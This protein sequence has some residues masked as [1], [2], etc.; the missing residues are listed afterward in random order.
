MPRGAKDADETWLYMRWATD[1]ANSLRLVA[2]AFQDPVHASNRLKPPYSD[3]PQYRAF[4]E[5]YKT[6]RARPGNPTYRLTE[7]STAEE[8]QAAYKGL[9]SPPDAV[10]AA[11]AKA[12][13][14]IQQNTKQ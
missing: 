6:A 10:K 4:V 8:L 5:Q 14:I 2:P 7:E 3:V 9:K 12:V 11:V 13:A 1:E